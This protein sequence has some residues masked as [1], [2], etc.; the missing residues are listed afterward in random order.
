MVCVL[1]LQTVNIHCMSRFFVF[2][3][4]SIVHTFFHQLHG[5]DIRQ[6]ATKIK[7]YLKVLYIVCYFTLSEFLHS[8]NALVRIS[9]VIE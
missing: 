9:K 4:F 3:T 8:V 2:A 5:D 1:S 7:N 6:Y